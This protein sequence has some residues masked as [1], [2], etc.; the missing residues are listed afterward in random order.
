MQKRTTTSTLARWDH[1][2]VV[3]VI[4]RS[5]TLTAAATELGLD[6][7]TVARQLSSLEQEL[8]TPLFE[9]SRL[10]LVATPFGEEVIAVC[11]GMESEVNGLL[12]RMDGV[13]TNLTGNVRLTATFFLAVS[14]IAPAMGKFL[15]QHP[16]LDIDLIADDRA[17]D[18]SRREADIALRLSRPKA[19]GLVGRKV[20][21][22][23]FDW[24]ISAQHPQM[25]DEPAWLV[26]QDA[27]GTSP[28]MRHM[29]AN[30]KSG[31]ITLR[32]NSMHTLIEAVRAGAGCSLLP[33]F[34]GNHDRTLRKAEVPHRPLSMPLWITYHEDLRR[35]PRIKAV[36]NF[37]A[38][39]IAERQ[40]NLDPSH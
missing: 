33:C 5:G 25:G 36:A 32:C 19:S 37:L 24:Y 7:T 6:H 27:T 3:G 23:A 1:L 30:S 21:S 40:M 2:R 28:L 13:T 9:R 10:G 8:G 20:G 4:A 18:I 22:I 16:G 29:L 17:L 39:L 14:V 31:R 12:R 38:T 34:V 35:S 15:C 11:D 26:Y